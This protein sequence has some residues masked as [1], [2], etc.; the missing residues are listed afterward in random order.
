MSM[1]SLQDARSKAQTDGFEQ[2]TVIRW[3]A[4]ERYTYAALKA[5]GLWYTTAQEFNTRVPQSVTF[6][7]LLEILSRS[8]VSDVAVATDWEG[9]ED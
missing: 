9:V 5:G 8:E 3:I 4:S 1:K 2:G 7:K 6:E